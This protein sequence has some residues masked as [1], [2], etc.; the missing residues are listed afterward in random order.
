L[1]LLESGA[2][3]YRY[4]IGLISYGVRVEPAKHTQ[5]KRSEAADNQGRV[6]FWLATWEVV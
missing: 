6:E 1:L 3:L 4:I 2:E 5:A